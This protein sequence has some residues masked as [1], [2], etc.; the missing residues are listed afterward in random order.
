MQWWVYAIITMLMFGITNFLVKVA[1]YHNMDSVFTSILLWLAVGAMG[2]V[3][4]LYYVHTGQFQEEWSSVQKVYLLLP[5]IAGIT[6]AIGM[7]TIKL[8]L[9]SGPGGPTVAIA[10]ANA[11]LI[12]VL[13]FIFLGE[14]LSVSKIAG[15]LLIFLG[16]AVMTML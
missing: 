10:A 16:V 2:L 15:M 12:A 3:F 9:T 4:L 7:Y 13:A 14:E 6:L 5:I 11:F 8:A 1:G